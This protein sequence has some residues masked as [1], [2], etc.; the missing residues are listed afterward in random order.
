MRCDKACEILADMSAR[1][2]QFRELLLTMEDKADASGGAVRISLCVQLTLRFN[3]S[4]RMRDTTTFS[5]ELHS[6]TPCACPRNVSFPKK[7]KG[8]KTP[9]VGET[10][11]DGLARACC[12]TALNGRGAS[13]R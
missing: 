1:F 9:V 12:G 5:R 13:R 3:K 2:V 10:N 6:V 8:T 7:F 11:R 4:C